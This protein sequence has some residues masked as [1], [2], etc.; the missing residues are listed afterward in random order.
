MFFNDRYVVFRQNTGVAKIPLPLSRFLGENMAKVLFLVLHLTRSG[1]RIPLCGAL[2]S[3]H[4]RHDI[5]SLRL[6]L[7]IFGA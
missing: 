1:E 6:L 2:F 7:L 5:T 3:F 4:F